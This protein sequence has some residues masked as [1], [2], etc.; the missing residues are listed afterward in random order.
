M[1]SWSS[2]VHAHKHRGR[3]VFFFFF[4]FAAL[5]RKHFLPLGPW[6]QQSVAGRLG[7]TLLCRAGLNPR[8]TPPQWRQSSDWMT[9][10]LTPPLWSP[11]QSQP[12][13]VG[14]CSSTCVWNGD[15]RLEWH[16][17]E[18]EEKWFAN[19]VWVMIL[20]A[21]PHVLNADIEMVTRA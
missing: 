21:G 19:L 12:G 10:W 5:R 6:V 7:F 3:G 15:H 18:S 14:G 4:F 1:L 11:R 8:W 2:L 9:D 16:L 13:W 17:L 20:R